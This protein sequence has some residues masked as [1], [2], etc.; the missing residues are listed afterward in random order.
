MKPLK[1]YF[2]QAAMVGI[3]ALSGCQKDELSS[4]NLPDKNHSARTASINRP[5]PDDLTPPGAVIIPPS[6][7]IKQEY[8]QAT[9]WL[10]TWNNPIEDYIYSLAG[11]FSTVDGSFHS[12]NSLNQSSQENTAKADMVLLPG[13]IQ[14]LE[15][16]S[17]L[18]HGAFAPAT[19]FKPSGLSLIGFMN[20]V[21]NN[22]A[23]FQQEFENSPYFS[24]ELQP[25][26][27]DGGDW[28]YYQTGEIYLFKTD[29]TPAVYGAVRIVDA[30]NVWTG[31]SPRVLQIVVQKSNAIKIPLK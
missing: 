2:L 8:P 10:V 12:F 24:T 22:P 27:Y 19:Q 14:S 20:A 28:V 18:V 4:L 31:T 17:V 11:I 16:A 7:V 21:Q 25:Y 1:S 5:A 30:S 9:S 15:G 6:S 29:R 3:C 26:P 13:R 23:L